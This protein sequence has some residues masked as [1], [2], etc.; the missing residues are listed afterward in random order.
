MPVASP[1]PCSIHKIASASAESCIQSL[2]TARTEV[3]KGSL[4]SKIKVCSEKFPGN[5][6]DCSFDAHRKNNLRVL[7]SATRLGCAYYLSLFGQ[8]PRLQASAGQGS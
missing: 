8:R 2:R 4:A 3:N 6:G 1:P 7:I 5:Q